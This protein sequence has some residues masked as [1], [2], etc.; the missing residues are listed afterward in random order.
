M[1]LP[2]TT[3]VDQSIFPAAF[4]RRNSSLCRRSH[5]PD[6]CQAA[7]RR[8]A[9]AGE[10][11]SSR[12]RCRHA[13]PVNNTNTIALKH[14]R[15][16][17]RGRPPRGS[18]RCAGSNGSDLPQLVA[19]PPH[20]RRHQAPPDR[21]YVYPKRSPPNP[22]TL[23]AQVLRQLLSDGLRSYGPINRYRSAAF[24]GIALRHL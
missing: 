15:S 22:Q 20:R 9:V 6:F 24:V 17:T 8:C 7:S 5:T 16:S 21:G 12:G 11:P 23:P 18:G 4:S 1:W 3:A 2:S 14:T 10:Q 19:N 13:I